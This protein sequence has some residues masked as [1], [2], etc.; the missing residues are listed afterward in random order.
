MTPEEEQQKAIEKAVNET[1]TMM[2]MAPTREQRLGAARVLELMPP[3]EQKEETRIVLRCVRTPAVAGE[4]AEGW[5]G[6]IEGNSGMLSI[7]FK[8][9]SAEI[10]TFLAGVAKLMVAP[11]LTDEEFSEATNGR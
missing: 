8:K 2:L 7:T 1:L 10:V 3:P 4:K 9:T 11:H 5:C 6:V